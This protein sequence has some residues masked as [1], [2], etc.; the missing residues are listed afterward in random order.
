MSKAAVETFIIDLKIT[1]DGDVKILELGDLQRSGLSGYK[2]STGRNLTR[3]HV[4]PFI[5]RLGPPVFQSGSLGHTLQDK[6]DDRLGIIPLKSSSEPFDPGDISTYGATLIRYNSPTKRQQD[7]LDNAC[8]GRVLVTNANKLACAAYNNKAIFAALAQDTM[9]HLLPETQIYAVTKGQVDARQ[10]IKDFDGHDHVV[11]K[12][13]ENAR[14][15]GVDIRTLKSIK[16]NHIHA[17]RPQMCRIHTKFKMKR[18]SALVVQEMIKGRPLPIK[19]ESGKIKHYDPVIRVVATAYRTKG[20]THIEFHDAYYKIP[21]KP[22]SD[23]FNRKS[24][25]SDVKNGPVSPVMSAEDKDNIFK[26]LEDGLVPFFSTLFTENPYE[27]VYE[28]LESATPLMQNL[29]AMVA[30]RRDYFEYG[31]ITR[32]SL[33]KRLYLLK[34]QAYAV[35]EAL[36]SGHTAP[37]KL[38][39]DLRQHAVLDGS[40]NKLK[41]ADWR[42]EHPALMMFGPLA[43]AIASSM[44]IS[45]LPDDLETELGKS[46][47]KFFNE[48]ARAHEINRD[49]YI[50]NMGY[51]T[52]RDPTDSPA[53][54]ISSISETF[55]LSVCMTAT[56]PEKVYSTYASQHM[57]INYPEERFMSVTVNNDVSIVGT[58]C[59]SIEWPAR[60]KAAFYIQGEEK[61]SSQQA[62]APR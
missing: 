13:P 28:W 25:I 55:G 9:P 58:T 11:L 2:R 5:E 34:E 27:L 42:R 46:Y 19:T 20:Q 39:R 7:F 44:I 45:S 21:T 6:E 33:A 62:L 36:A 23:K 22:M 37:S 17:G 1:P 40:I 47:T 8:G 50:E 60:I 41:R 54:T 29:G 61:Q 24:S 49:N 32:P 56:S 26:Q 53:E 57:A 18:D 52:F 12:Q 51:F 48:K 14:S 59:P 4:Y 35:K 38:K 31:E 43:I 16:N 30:T 15:L 3:S 10:I